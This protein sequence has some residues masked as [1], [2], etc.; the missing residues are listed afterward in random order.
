MLYL[1]LLTQSLRNLDFQNARYQDVVPRDYLSHLRLITRTTLLTNLHSMMIRMTLHLLDDVLLLLP[2]ILLQGDQMMVM[3][4]I[5]FRVRLR[6]L[7]EDHLHLDLQRHL[8]RL[9]SRG[10]AL[11]GRVINR[12]RNQQD[13]RVVRG[14]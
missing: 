3:T 14:V 1:P 9:K 2:N 12:L 5:N 6:R 11:Q 13:D 10:V 8:H 4:M 7:C